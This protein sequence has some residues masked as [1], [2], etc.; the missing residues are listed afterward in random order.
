MKRRIS[1]V[2]KSQYN[3]K[4]HLLVKKK[5]P[6][7]NTWTYGIQDHNSWNS[8]SHYSRHRDTFGITL[9][10]GNYGGFKTHK[11]PLRRSI[12]TDD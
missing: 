8:I 10:T 11:Y 9:N 4:K 7:K 1:L 5:K 12:Y 3:L 2:P 6:N